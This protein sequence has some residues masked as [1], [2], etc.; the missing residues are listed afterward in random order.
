MKILWVGDLH[1]RQSD[2][3]SLDALFDRIVSLQDSH[4]AV[5]LAGDIYNDHGVSHAK[6]QERVFSLFDRLNKKPVYNI[7]GNHD[8]TS[9]GKNSS[10][11]VHLSQSVVQVTEKSGYLAMPGEPIALVPYYRNERDF[12]LAANAALMRGAKILFCHQEFKGAF[13]SKDVA[14]SQGID[15]RAFPEGTVFISG[16][17]HNTQR[18]PSINMVFYPGAPRWLTK[19]DSNSSRGLWSFEFKSGVMSDAKIIESN[20]ICPVFWDV[21]VSDDTLPSQIKAGDR[22]YVTYSGD[23]FDAFVSKYPSVNIIAKVKPKVVSNSTSVSEHVGVEASISSFID[24]TMGIKTDKKQ[25]LDSI[26]KRVLEV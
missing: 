23:S 7:E 1:V 8:K 13:Y 3:G 15:P 16:H 21:D 5:I 10:L 4:D 22:V 11:S 6:V 18:V 12:Y 19:S 20:D 2:G 26:L 9:D 14:T 17:F 25:L 24:S